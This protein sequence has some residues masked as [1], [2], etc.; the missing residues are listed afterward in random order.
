MKSVVKTIGGRKK[1]G[2]PL[3]LHTPGS[4]AFVSGRIMLFDSVDKGKQPFLKSIKEKK[5]FFLKVKSRRGGCSPPQLFP[6]PKLQEQTQAYSYSL[7]QQATIQGKGR[8]NSTGKI[9]NICQQGFVKIT[10]HLFA[11]RKR[12][13]SSKFRVKIKYAT[14]LFPNSERKTVSLIILNRQLPQSLC[15]RRYGTGTRRCITSSLFD[16][17]ST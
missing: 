11:H 6:T 13:P 4:T 12:E 9:K 2:P 17:T 7:T 3:T 8:C 15:K 10:T 14:S 5:S 1:K 16:Q